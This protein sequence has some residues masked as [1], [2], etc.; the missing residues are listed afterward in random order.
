MN[1]RTR[2]RELAERR[3]LALKKLAKVFGTN[4]GDTDD[5]RAAHTAEKKILLEILRS[6]REPDVVGLVRDR[7]A[8]LSARDDSDES[9]E[10]WRS[11]RSAQTTRSGSV[12]ATGRDASETDDAFSCETENDTGEPDLRYCLLLAPESY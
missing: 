4:G 10:D 3:A 8:V 9:D 6:T 2:E 12:T 7:L 11:A 5:G 1:E